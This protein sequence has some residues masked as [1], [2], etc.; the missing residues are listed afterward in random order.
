MKLV[1]IIPLLFFIF[2][3][4]GTWQTV[5]EVIHPKY[6]DMRLA[7][8]GVAIIQF[9]GAIGAGVATIFVIKDV[10]WWPSHD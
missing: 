2:F 5:G 10:P 3:C 7:A 9:T 6:V 1:A 4:L 8:F